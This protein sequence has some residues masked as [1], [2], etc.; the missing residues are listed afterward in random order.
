MR[1]KISWLTSN[2]FQY[3]SPLVCLVPSILLAPRLNTFEGRAQRLY[4]QFVVKRFTQERHCPGRE[5]SFAH[6]DL[7]V[8]R[9]KDNPKLTTT[10]R[11]SLL[12]V[13]T[14]QP[15]H[16]YVENNTV[17]LEGWH[18]LNEIG[19]LLARGKCVRLHSQ[20]AHQSLNRS[21]DRLI[22]IN[23]GDEWFSFFRDEPF[24]RTT[25]NRNVIYIS[26]R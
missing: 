23:D 3:S 8:R 10:I 22:V 19:K 16:L 6:T 14:I 11:Q 2:K 13:Q 24:L 12:H 9:D 25:L 7:V 26:D 18:G 21:T 20:R 5:R 17:R 1:L 15:W 4:E